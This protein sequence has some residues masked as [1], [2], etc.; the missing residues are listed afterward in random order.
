[1]TWQTYCIMNT[2]QK[3]KNIFTKNILMCKYICWYNPETKQIYKETQRTCSMIFPSSAE[4][5]QWKPAFRLKKR[6]LV[7]SWATKSASVK[8]NK[9]ISAVQGGSNMTTWW[10]RGDNQEQGWKKERICR[11]KLFSH[12]GINAVHKFSCKYNADCVHATCKG[13]LLNCFYQQFLLRFTLCL[14]LGFVNGICQ[15]RGKDKSST[16]FM[17]GM[18]SLSSW[19][20]YSDSLENSPKASL[21]FKNKLSLSETFTYFAFI[22][23]I[24]HH[25]FILL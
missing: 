13:L 18:I 8:A 6:Y 23:H 14:C 22:F 11:F 2:G 4:Q 9:K 21:S 24:L 17:F 5:D 10:T 7:Y 25:E 1:M 15:H 12:R 20:V 19:S 16:L 3:S